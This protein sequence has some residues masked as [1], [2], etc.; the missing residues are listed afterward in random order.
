MSTNKVL[1]LC[2]YYR[3]GSTALCEHYSKKYNL[4][5]NDE[6]FFHDA[7]P[8]KV[9]KVLDSNSKYVLKIIASQ[10]ILNMKDKHRAYIKDVFTKDN[11][12][13]I[14]LYRKNI[15]ESILSMAHCHHTNTWHNK[16][17]K[18][19]NSEVDKLVDKA[20]QTYSNEYTQSIGHI[21]QIIKFIKPNKV[22]EYTDVLNLPQSRFKKSITN[23][24]YNQA[25]S[26]INNKLDKQLTYESKYFTI[27]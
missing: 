8:D 19:S 1:I 21:N 7:D 24:Y 12:E 18:I 27:T 16:Q 22:L 13:V 26:Q 15:S 25:L 4:S 20:V 6:M 10:W 5:N 9:L 23:E 17:N 11:T 2:A 3:C 14:L